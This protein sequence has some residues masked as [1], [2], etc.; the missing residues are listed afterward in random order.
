MHSR[1]RTKAR[2]NYVKE[3]SSDAKNRSFSLSISNDGC[4]QREGSKRGSLKFCFD[5][6]LPPACAHHFSTASVRAHWLAAARCKSSSAFLHWGMCSQGNEI[7]QLVRLEKYSY[8]VSALKLIVSFFVTSVKIVLFLHESWNLE[9][10]DTI[11]L[12]ISTKFAFL[13]SQTV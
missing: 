2:T 11:F 8:G 3:I 5:L 4:C 1:K 7:T 9:S 12:P 10:I 13:Q 6:N